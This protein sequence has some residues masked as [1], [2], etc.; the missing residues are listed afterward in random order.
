MERKLATVLFVDLVDSTKLVS[1][2]DPEVVRRRVSDFFT[3][4]AR[5]VEEYGGTVEKFAGDAVMAAFGVPRAHE[6]DAERAVRA[7]FSVMDVVHEIGLEARAGVEAGE[8]V[9]EEADS[10][11]ATGEAVNTAARLQQSAPPGAI[12]L[13]PGAR[14]LLGSA[15]EV[16]ESPPLEIQ[17]RA[18]PLSTWRVVRMLDGRPRADAAAFVGRDAEL[19]LLHNTYARSVRDRRSHLVTVVGEP[20]VGKSRLVSEFLAGVERATVLSGRTLPYGEGVTYWPLA[21]MIKESAGISDDDPAAEAFE[22]LRLSCESE[23]VADL[24]AAALGVL[25]A[26]DDERS[27]EELAWAA[28]RW[29]EQLAEAQPLVLVFDDVQWSEDRLLDLI[30][31]LAPRLRRVPVMVVCVA[32]PELFEKRPAWGGGSARSLAL[33]V[34]PL[35]VTE[36]EE[37]AAA[38]LGGDEVA[39]EQRAL[40]LEKAEGNPLFLAETARMV[41]GANGGASLERVP[42]TVQAVIAARIDALDTGQKRSL[43]RAALIGRAFWRGALEAL[44][45]GDDVDALLDALLDRELILPEEHSTLKSER[46]YRFTHGLIREVAYSGIS[47]AQRATDHR[48]FAAWLGQ[49]AADELPDIR[50]YHLDHAAALLAELEGT[51]P[52]DLAREAAAELEA[53]GRR[54]LRRAEFRSARR[55]LT[56]ATELEPTLPRRALAAHAAWRLS[57]VPTVRDE[58]AGALRDARAAG[59]RDIEGLA[60]VLLGEIALNADSDVARASELAD[61]ALATFPADEARGRYDAHTLVAAIAWWTGD[62]EGSRRHGEA[63]IELAAAMQRPDLESLALTQLASVTSVQDDLERARELHERARRLAEESGS[64]EAIGLALAMSAGTAEA[65]QDLE[66]AEDEIEEACAVFD[67]IGAAGRYAWALTR[68]GAIQAEQGELE[69]AE[70][71]LRE[72]VRRLRSTH[73]QGFLVEAE[74]QLA[75]VLVSRGEIREAEQLALDARQNVGREDV[76]TRASAGQALGHVRAAQGRPE[77]AEALLQ[78]ALSILEPTMYR[79]FAASVREDLETLRK[80]PLPD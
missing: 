55:L 56:R 39:P 7:A 30:E 38:L 13:G 31:H 54:C 32:R 70:Q 34:G 61:A 80:T 29:A 72:A 25:G 52:T 2:A 63:M 12:L 8:L 43:Q 33:E 3:R 24:L 22:K 1:G 19:D 67:E 69:A 26:T 78:E 51:V 5:C 4:A 58:A 18:Q 36:A 11:F 64:R 17:G 79:R 60:L 6:D 57:D 35:A 23:A 42:D 66:R 65:E 53:A 50:A 27:P 71:V 46:A 47:K 21:S 20:G 45:P 37:L 48:A 74:R 77:A 15:T 16:E 59:Q 73:D 75:E 9:V 76:W 44:T 10:T 28:L 62:A 68:R 40:V 49:Q 41:A 14:R